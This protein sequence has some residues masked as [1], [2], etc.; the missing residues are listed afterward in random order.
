MISNPGSLMALVWSTITFFMASDD[1]NSDVVTSFFIGRTYIGKWQVISSPSSHA[2][3]FDRSRSRNELD[4]SSLLFSSW[5]KFAG[6]VIDEDRPQS[7]EYGRNTSKGRRYQLFDTTVT[8][9]KDEEKTRHD[10]SSARDWLEWC[11]TNGTNPSSSG[12]PQFG[13]Y[14]VIRCDL[15]LPPPSQP[16]SSLN[17]SVEQRKTSTS[18]STSNALGWKIWGL[19]FHLRRLQESY[20][21]MMSGTDDD[22]DDDEKRNSKIGLDFSSAVESSYYILELLLEEA[23]TAIL[24]R[25][26]QEQETMNDID[27]SN[28][29]TV[30]LTL[31]WQPPIKKVDNIIDRNQRMD[32]IPNI[33]VLGHAF[34]SL[35]AVPI[36]TK[37][38]NPFINVAVGRIPYNNDLHDDLPTRYLDHPEAKLSSWCKNRRPLEEIFKSNRSEYNI[39]EVIL[40][41][42]F[43]DPA[44]AATKGR[45]KLSSVSLLEG[46]TSNLFVV[47]DNNVIRTPPFEDS[48]LNGYARHLILENAQQCGYTVE[49]GPILLDDIQSWKEVFVTSS[50]RLIVPVQKIFD[51]YESDDGSFQFRKIW[52]HKYDDT[53]KT[54]TKLVTDGLYGCLMGT[55]Y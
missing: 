31:L 34:T 14:T 29:I 52:Q 50:I 20:T 28:I 35:N 15:P 18:T 2:S 19:N 13:A 46:L 21:T 33:H 53:S 25:Q 16:T 42:M 10:V 6:V 9:S 36:Q 32:D 23:S 22:G 45:K 12:D 8:S 4:S 49:L 27:R 48:A 37:N 7:D 39:G 40:T 24:H 5:S 26:E 47:Y 41:R 3:Y 30:M 38:P 43:E 54:S 11:A 44:T 17:I 55:K 51:V 1:R